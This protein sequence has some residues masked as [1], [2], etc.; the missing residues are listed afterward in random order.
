[1]GDGRDKVAVMKTCKRCQKPGRFRPQRLTCMDCE[2]ALQTARREANPISSEKQREWHL[3]WRK[4]HGETARATM[5]ATNARYRERHREEVRARQRSRDQD[6][7][8]IARMRLARNAK[9]AI[10]RAVKA[11]RMT[12]PLVCEQCL[13][14]GTIEAAH[15]DYS[16]PLQVRWLCQSC[17]RREDA[18]HPK[19]R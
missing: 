11:G 13:K 19:T 9:N 18:L 15:D 4:K 5:T 7:D 3:N 12:R 1:M 16:K 17:H 10:Q 14:P 2:A 8:Y 6:P